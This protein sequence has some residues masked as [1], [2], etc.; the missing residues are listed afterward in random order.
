MTVLTAYAPSYLPWKALFY[1]IAQADVFVFTDTD[2]LNRK[3]FH[4]RNQVWTKNGPVWLTVPVLGGR[5][6]QLRDVVIDQSKPWKRKHWDTLKYAYGKTGFYDLIA[7]CLQLPYWKTDKLAEL[8][9]R[10]TC[11]VKDL[12]DL[13]ARVHRAGL[14]DI[15]GHGSE[16]ILNMCKHFDADTYLCGAAGRD[17]LDLEAFKKE[18]IEVRIEDYQGAPVSVVHDL[19]TEGPTL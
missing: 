18:G 9:D 16:F 3:D 10:L 8:N 14:N 5:D 13:P 11:A 2:R 6:Q 19:F 4:T 17:Y 7:F 12:Y 15:Q 1:R